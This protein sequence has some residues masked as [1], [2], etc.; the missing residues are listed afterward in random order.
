MHDPILAELAKM[1]RSRLEGLSLLE[2][3]IMKLFDQFRDATKMINERGEDASTQSM[4]FHRTLGPRS[5]NDL[6]SIR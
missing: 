4:Q 1:Q 2:R 3:E 6:H 5:R